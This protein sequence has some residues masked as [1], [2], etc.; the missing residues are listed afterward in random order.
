MKEINIKDLKITIDIVEILNAISL[1]KKIEIDIDGRLYLDEDVE[2]NKAIIFSLKKYDNLSTILDAKVLVNNIFKNYKPS[3]NG[4]IC[5]LSPLSAWQ[6]IIFLNQSRMLYFDHQTDGVELFEE[7]ELENI[8]WNAV[9]CDI[10][11]R[12]IST[13]IESNCSG[14]LVYYDNEVQ[15]NGFAIVDSIQDTKIKVKDFIIMNI[16]EK[17]EK[18]I[19]DIEDDDVIEALEF[20]KIKV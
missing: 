13:F 19:I 3:I 8:G 20:F 16:K 4:T 7:K 15:F 17:I 18:E 5:V 14:T 10:S 1:N 2:L 12:E 6:E 11:Y 9:A